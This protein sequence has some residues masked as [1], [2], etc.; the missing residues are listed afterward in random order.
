M[1]TVAAYRRVLGSPTM[2]RFL[3][4]MGVSALGDGMSVVVIAWLAITIAPAEQAGAWTALALAAFSLPA[5]VG[6]LAF[7]RIARRLSGAKL[8]ACDATLRAAALGAV[9][10]LGA[11]GQL[12]P[13]LY[14]ALLGVSSLWHAWG[15]AGMYTLVA[16]ALPSD[17]HVVGN[18]LLGTGTQTA[19]IV[20]PA[21]A[22]LLVPAIGPAGAIGVDALSWAVLAAVSWTI[23]G[24]TRSH[25]EAAKGDWRA[26]FRYPQLLGL[27]LITCAFFFLYGPVEVAL[28]VHVV[29]DEH[30]SAAMLGAFWAVF[31]IGAVVGGLAAAT[32]RNRPLGTVVVFIIVGWGLALLPLGLSG[33]LVPGLIGFAVG[34]VIYGP[35][36][37]VTSAMVQR[38]S[39]PELLSRV[40]ATRGALTIPATSLGAL[41]GGPLVGWLG[42]RETLLA[43]AIATVALG[44]GVGVAQLRSSQNGTAV[45]EPTV[46]G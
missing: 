18:S 16:E 30:G 45:A 29:L 11:T 10:V 31:G 9:A 1:Q 7:G 42:A 27:V 33:R 38:T 41:A 23:A 36:T 20:G 44:L 15:L 43:S 12:T 22:G 25:A 3:P 17:D 32:L 40:L 8:V 6:A 24:P 37:S 34:G 21:L 13:P 5:T 14:V 4:A 19:Y 46:S 26:L 35:F 39:P 28:P 2:R